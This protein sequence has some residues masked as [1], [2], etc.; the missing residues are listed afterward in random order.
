MYE[1]CFPRSNS[2]FFPSA[3]FTND[4]ERSLSETTAFDFVV[5][6]IISEVTQQEMIDGDNSLT[7]AIILTSTLL[8]MDLFLTLLKWPFT[9]FERI[10]EGT[11][12]IIVEH[13]KP[14]K[15]EWTKQK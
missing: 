2:V 4:G 13:G 12:L 1:S 15:K 8:G 7:R 10:V 6:L 14:L 5:L 11:P 9:L 3:R